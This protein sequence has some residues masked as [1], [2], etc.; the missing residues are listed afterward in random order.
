MPI[1][2]W[3]LLVDQVVVHC[4]RGWTPTQTARIFQ[5]SPLTIASW[6]GRLD[7]EGSDALV[8]LPEQPFVSYLDLVQTGSQRPT[9]GESFSCMVAT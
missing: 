7:E 1:Q 4:A 3:N 9:E 5:V 6:M 2:H 8:C